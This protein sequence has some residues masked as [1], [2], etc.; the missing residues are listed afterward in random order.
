LGSRYPISDADFWDRCRMSRLS[1]SHLTRSTTSLS[2]SPLL[3]VRALAAFH[4]ASTR[5]F[6]SCPPRAHHMSHGCTRYRD[7]TPTFSSITALPFNT[8]CDGNMGLFTCVPL[9]G[10]KSSFLVAV[11]I[12]RSC[13]RASASPHAKSR[14]YSGEKSE[15]G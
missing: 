5:T 15:K 3:Y 13:A 9:G 1:T 6:N 8:F 10:D 2:A 12:D 11:K 7:L 4:S 14:L